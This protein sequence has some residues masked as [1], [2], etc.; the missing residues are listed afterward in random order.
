V[1]GV[2]AVVGAALGVVILRPGLALMPL[3]RVA[4][5]A[6][7]IFRR[8]IDLSAVEGNAR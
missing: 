6:V 3:R 7:E 2:T 8:L 4:V 1:W 5:E